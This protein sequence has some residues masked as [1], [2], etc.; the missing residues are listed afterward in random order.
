MPLT[1]IVIEANKDLLGEYLFCNENDPPKILLLEKLETIFDSF[2]DLNSPN[3]I[4]KVTL[5]K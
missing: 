4:N 5:F 1:K 3:L 2:K